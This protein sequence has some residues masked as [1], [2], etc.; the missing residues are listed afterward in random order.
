MTAGA[1]YGLALYS[2]AASEALT[3]ELFEQLKTL[4]ESFRAEPGFLKL[5]SAPALSKVERCR[6]IDDSFGTAVHEYV[7]STLKLM[8][9]R[10]CICAFGGCFRA[11]KEHYYEDKGLMEVTVVTAAALTQQQCD[12]LRNKLCRVTGKTVLL[13][14]R[15]EPSCLGGIRLDYAGHRLDDTVAHRLDAIRQTLAQTV[16]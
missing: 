3:D 7:R 8:T 15:V 6:I 4:D 10:G 14:P 2:L 11:Y 13:C 1:D 12:A 16:I 9:E 5:L